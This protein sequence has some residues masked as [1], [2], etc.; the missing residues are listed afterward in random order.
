MWPK[1]YLQLH[2]MRFFLSMTFLLYG[3][4][5]YITSMPIFLFLGLYTYSRL[6]EHFAEFSAFFC[7]FETYA[8]KKTYLNIFKKIKSRNVF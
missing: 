4:S 6:L 1:S 3:A 2:F 5:T 8:Y 7:I